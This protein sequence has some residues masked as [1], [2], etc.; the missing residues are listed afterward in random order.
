MKNF[1]IEQSKLWEHINQTQITKDKIQDL[2]DFKSSDVNFR[3]TLWDPKT[4]GLRYLKLLLYNVAASMPSEIFKKI[5]KIKNRDIGNPI[6][7]KYNSEEI[8]LDYLQAVFELDFIEQHIRIDG[9]SILEIGAGYGRT[10][11]SIISNHKIKSYSI[12]DLENCLNLSCRYLKKVL[13]KSDFSKIK[14][15]EVKD[16]HLLD[17]SFFDICIN[18]DSFA[19]MEPNVVK[20]YLEYINQ[21]CHYFYVKN[22]VGK[23]M[24]KSLDN[25]HQGQE[26]VNIALNT[27]V[28]RDVIDIH[29]NQ[30][31]KKKAPKFIEAYQ[32]GKKWECIANSW[33]RPWSY[34]WQAIYKKIR[35]NK[36]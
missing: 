1:K 13:N 11:H 19:E 25:H 2:K 21:N 35:D 3:I 20:Y 24:D 28:L 4:N 5:L 34:F 9:L 23:Y 8:C 14:F 10:C 16:F 18:I 22:P 12:I 17:N 27:G 30:A 31:I 32:P 7:I 15:V 6:T 29:D 26:L 36:N 33:A